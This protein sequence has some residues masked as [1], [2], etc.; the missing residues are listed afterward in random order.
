M[1]LAK[2]AGWLCSF[3]TCR[4]ATVGATADDEHA[5]DI[6]IAAHICAAAPLGPR[7]NPTQSSEERSSV[8]NGIWMCQDHSKVID[9]ADAEFTVAQLLEW[10]KQA[11][12]ESRMRVLHNKSVAELGIFTGGQPDTRLRDAARADLNVF[13]RTLT[14]PPTSVPL[15][16][17]VDGFDG[18]VET[19]ALARASVALDDL[20]LVA[21]PG[22]GKT[23]TLFQI[24]EGLLESGT[25]I[26]LVVPLADWATDGVGVLEALLRRPAF[27]A[28]SEGDL[29]A[30]ADRPGVVLLLDGWNE[31]DAQARKRARVQVDALKAQLPNI[32]LV[33]SS[34][35][36]TFE[37]PFDGLR[38]ELLPLDER[39]QLAMATAMRADDGIAFLDRAWRT[40]GVRDLVTIPLYLTTLLSLPNG[41]PFPTTKEEV[42]RQFVASHEHDPGHAETLHAAT[43]GFHQDYLVRLAA[44]ATGA[45]NTSIS[46]NDARRC[47]VGTANQLADGWQISSKPQPDEVLGVLV[48][49]HL[50][51]RTGDAT[52]YSFQHQQFQEW[53]AADAVE[54][55]ILAEIDCRSGR[56]ALQAEIFDHLAWEEAVLFAIERMAR[57][58]A[59]K[60]IACSKAIVAAFEVDPNL[61]AEMIQRATDEVWARITSTI[62][63]L[64]VR[65]HA[66]GK[67]D[68]AF[69]FML[70]SGRVEFFDAVWPL[71][72][73]DNDE[74]SLGALRH[75]ERFRSSI[76]G[77]DAASKIEK[78]AI[79]PRAVLLAEMAWHGDIDA[80]NLASTIA[81][82]DPDPKV[83]GGVIDALAF[84]RAEHHIAAIL[85]E[86][87]DS[88]LDLVATKG[89]LDEV[90]DN[91]IHEVMARFRERSA[92][93]EMSDYDRLRMIVRANDS[94]DRDDELADL[95][96]TVAIDK[97]RDVTVDLIRTASTRHPA[98]VARGLVARLHAGR[99]LFFGADDLLVSAGIILEND[100]LLELALAEPATRNDNADAAASLLGPH[101]AGRLIDA[102]LDLDSGLRTAGQYPGDADEALAGLQSRIAHVTGA[103]V[104]AAVL[105][106]S[107]GANSARQAQL[108]KLLSRPADGAPD[109]SRP[110]DADARATICQLLAEWGDLMLA[111]GDA[112]R[113]EMAALARLAECVPD[114][115]LLPV[116]GRLLDD[117]L[118]RY[119]GFWA[120]A[121]AGRWQH[122]P[123]LNE[124]RTLYTGNYC[125]AFV[126]IRSPH[127]TAMMNAYLTDPH[128]GELAA[129][130]LCQH[131]RIANEPPTDRYLL[132]GVDF[133]RVKDNHK[134]R[135]FDP[136]RTS[137]EADT[138][139]A[140]AE[141]LISGDATDEQNRL[142]VA[143]GTIAARLPHGQRAD[144]I[145]KL[146]ALASRRKRP[147]LLLNL[148]L[149]GDDI[150]F[151][152]VAAG[153]EE[154]FEAAKTDGWILTQSDGFELKAWLRLLPFVGR[155]MNTLPVLRAMPPAQ[156]GPR[157]LAAMI[158]TF[159]HAPAPDAEDALFCLAQEDSRFYADYHWRHAAMRFGTSSAAQRIIELAAQGRLSHDKYDWDLTHELANLIA[160]FPDGRAQVYKLLES[161]III[162]GRAILARA[163]SESPD[164]DSFLLLVRLEQERNIDPVGD[165]AIE[166][167]FTE[168]VPI[169]GASGAYNVVP[170]AANG[171]RRRLLTMTTDGGKNDVAARYL[172]IIDEYRDRYGKPETEPRHPDFASGK[173]WPI[174]RPDPDAEGLPEAVPN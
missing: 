129:Q 8:K 157:F 70:V 119:R 86:A 21:P 47:V 133:S 116:L 35:K 145:G 161:D 59:Q 105:E 28:L 107:H 31:L 46:D 140:A 158:D 76:F 156:R 110:F 42:L 124:A 41:A 60:Q 55:R 137:T 25:G 125:R 38:I 90:T 94:I 109:R 56:A 135:I 43:Q 24:A 14:W 118:R 79:Q 12:L 147:D 120:K 54:R 131:W 99:M 163:L 66:P 37:V 16:L 80:L 34:R 18:P 98:A 92:L 20:I 173:P 32:G 172:R 143:L 136:D 50:L 2:R 64:L 148:V 15:T 61:A 162:P 29:R 115:R 87:G 113:S 152:V 71:I 11:E 13:R 81:R 5:I 91:E 106:R 149:S 57:G 117:E 126:A 166:R 138:I 52:G 100:A 114:Q 1:L 165:R 174:L 85:R 83:Q 89:I 104:V 97:P 19:K 155:V 93:R 121:E 78:L 95:I 128:F 130:V 154:T 67:I 146:I 23:T 153:I 122:G 6:G 167:V 26:P 45:A 101:A 169:E 170:I 62:Q 111:A 75:C 134:A 10:K 171:L 141:R 73:D 49:Q 88:T 142:A 4:K 65:W 17:R 68:R 39:Q 132:G 82:R 123:A 102:F 168:N 30:C 53:F 7:Y 74:I 27:R 159:P 84:R 3:P 9:S 48:S 112:T 40:A 33:V 77:P 58:N 36:Q 103:S 139:F 127:T 164:E 108:A 144:T 150:D 160:S 22:M 44:H 151:E 51:L 72:T 96:A 69:R 63:D